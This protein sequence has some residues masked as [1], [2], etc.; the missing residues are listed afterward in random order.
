MNTLSWRWVRAFLLVAEH[1][2]FT[3]AA[4]ASGQSRAN[5]SQQVTALER[6]LGVQLLHRTTRSLRLTATGQG[7]YERSLQAF[8]QLESAAEWAMQSSQELKGL[9]RMSSVGGLIGEEL[10]APAGVPFP[11]GASRGGG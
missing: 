8:R 11:A 6:A 7:Y 9:I 4:D 10:I 5:L 3:S 2:S 1:G